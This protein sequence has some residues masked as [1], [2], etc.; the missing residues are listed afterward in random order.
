MVTLSNS[1]NLQDPVM[2]GI[3]GPPASGK[4]W[5]AA[6]F[7]NPVFVNIDRGLTCKQTTTFQNFPFYDNDFCKTKMKFAVNRNGSINKRDGIKNWLLTEAQKLDADQTLVIDSWTSLQNAFDLQTDLE[8]VYTKSGQID[9]FAFWRTKIDYSRE[10]MTHLQSL[11]CKVVVL[12]H[13]RPVR[14]E[15][16]GQL[17]DKIEPLMQGQFVN[18][19]KMYFSDFFRQRVFSKVGRDGKP[20][21]INGKELTTDLTYMWQ[22]KSD[23][24]FDAKTRMTDIDVM[25][26]PANFTSLK[27]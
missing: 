11:R 6:T 24:T 20:T 1:T 16:S 9:D 21:M 26:I 19:L 27:Y 15:K 10:I 2:I 5:A 3:Q 4:T 12:F 25:F 18:Q 13:E 7:P 17:T 14:D 8:P 23:S 22:V